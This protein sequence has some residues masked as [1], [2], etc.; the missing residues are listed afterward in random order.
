MAEWNDEPVFI[1]DLEA[2]AKE[3]EKKREEV[4][5]EDIE[6]MLAILENFS[7]TETSRM[8]VVVSDEFQSGT[9]AKVKHHGRCDV[10]SPWA[11][12]QAFDVLEDAK[13][14]GCN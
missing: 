13:N 6:N 1:I 4:S 3:E 7:R 5:E 2:H 12:G 11:K 9:S 10:G 8:N 14:A